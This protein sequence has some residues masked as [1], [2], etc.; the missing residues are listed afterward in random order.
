[1]RSFPF[2]RSWTPSDGGW[3]LHAASDMLNDIYIVINPFNIV[4]NFNNKMKA[5]L[6]QNVN[7][8][9]AVCSENMTLM[10]SRSQK[11][12]FDFRG[13]K[14]IIRIALDV[15]SMSTAMATRNENEAT[16]KLNITSTIFMAPQC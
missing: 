13:K 8:L 7:R 3:S 14:A 11:N 15:E 16:S 5:K 1:M 6:V 9:L 4:Q 10:I 12:M 2:R